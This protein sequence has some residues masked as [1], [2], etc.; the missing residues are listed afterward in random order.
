MDI[1]FYKRVTP[2]VFANYLLANGWKERE[3]ERESARIFQYRRQYETFQITIPLNVTS[4][5]YDSMI[6]R[7][8]DLCALLARKSNEQVLFELTKVSIAK[9]Y[10]ATQLEESIDSITGC[11]TCKSPFEK[12]DYAFAL[13]TGTCPYCHKVLELVLTAE[14]NEL[15]VD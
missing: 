5:D 1:K 12:D 10:G 8:I 2:S 4:E 7:G 14:N 11:G 13:E 9:I 3:S 15:E 6:K